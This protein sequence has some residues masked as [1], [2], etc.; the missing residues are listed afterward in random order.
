MNKLF[1]ILFIILSIFYSLLIFYNKKNIERF[2]INNFTTVAVVGNGPITDKD[3]EKI[4]K[5][6]L[7]YRFNDCKNFKKGDKVTHLIVRQLGTKWKV[8][9]LN[10]N[11]EPIK[12]VNNLIFIGTRKELFNEIKNKNRNRDCRMIEVYEKNICKKINCNLNRSDLVIFN[13]KKIKQPKSTCG[14]S[15]GFIALADITNKY[16]NINVFGMN[17][18]FK[19]NKSHNGKW[20]KKIIDKFCKKCKIHLTSSNSY[21]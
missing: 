20:E 18:N 14:F 4:N 10:Y 17:W 1:I 7:V 19:K 12:D 11:F 5:C 2:R 6:D 15:S 21:I 8:S 13:N 3:R 16:N 9:G